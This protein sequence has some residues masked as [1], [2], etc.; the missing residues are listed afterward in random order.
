ME[1]RDW[2]SI[3]QVELAAQP[4]GNGFDH[5]ATV[6][7][8]YGPSLMIT[9]FQESSCGTTEM[10]RSVGHSQMSSISS[11]MT[12]SSSSR[13]S[14]ASSS[15]D[16]SDRSNETTAFGSPLEAPYLNG[17]RWPGKSKTSSR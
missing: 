10:A 11:L 8:C 14:L 6:R 1:G 3:F 16:H 12:A 5:L 17:G 7:A 9:T 13:F 15:L 4:I 2:R